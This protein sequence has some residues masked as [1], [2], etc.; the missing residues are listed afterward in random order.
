[1]RRK[2]KQQPDTP[3][4]INA[5]S[6]VSLQEEDDELLLP[7][8]IK[9]EKNLTALGFFSPSS[10]RL[11]HKKSKII[12]M[13]RIVEGRRKEARVTIVSAGGYGLPDIADQDKY[14]ALQKLIS[15]MR[16]RAGKV[17]NP[18]GFTSAELIRLLGKRV[19]T[20]KNYEAVS[21]W[22]KR[23]TLT[24]I[25]S[26]GAVYFA[27]K[28]AW[29]SD[30]FHVFDRAVS[31]GQE[32]PDGKVA[33]R[34]YV[35]LSEWQLE[36]I[37]NNHLLPIDYEEYKKLRNHIAKALV[38]LLQIWL[39]A[40]RETGYFEKRYD[41]LCAHLD[42]REYHQRSR[43]EE[44]LSPPLNELELHGYISRWKVEKT[45]EVKGYKII[46]YHGEKFHRDGRLRLA[47]RHQSIQPSQGILF[48]EREQAILKLVPDLV[49]RGITENQARKLLL[50]TD[51]LGRVTDQLEW[52]DH[53]IKE[54]SAGRF[55]NPAGFFVYLIRERIFPPSSFETS[56]L[57]RLRKEAADTSVQDHNRVAE[58]ELAYEEYVSFEVDR[59]INSEGADQYK[60]LME[61]KRQ[62]IVAKHSKLASRWDE[63]TL[64]SVAESAA[65]RQIS[66]EIS[67][68]NFEEFCKRLNHT[69]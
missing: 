35:W 20:G 29:A 10:K 21:E 63:M 39:F 18:I 1:M 32:L 33:D 40:T 65:R 56:R 5:E 9:I 64:A 11:K 54:G 51:D 50:V 49:R 60:C 2:N 44:Q 14:L 34:N 26:E 42:V 4:E 28:K 8:F 13:T 68:N 37:N 6:L 57:K 27:G 3:Q 62:E 53:L 61:A 17:S 38:P 59:Y 55:Y 25:V 15:E 31:L 12:T 23:M 22:L 47:Q 69:V 66:E 16:Q 30:T 7:D 45:S 24:G 52:G 43:I 41:E 67:L 48:S 19:S 46:F 36:N 58:L